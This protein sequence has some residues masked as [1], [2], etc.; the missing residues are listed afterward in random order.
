MIAPLPPPGPDLEELDH[1]MPA[2]AIRR[3]LV[4]PHRGPLLVAPVRIARDQV[5]LPLNRLFR[6]PEGHLPC[7]GQ[8]CPVGRPAVAVGVAGLFDHG[9]YPRGQVDHVQH[10]APSFLPG[11]LWT[12]HGQN[13]PVLGRQ[14]GALS[15]LL[16]R[17]QEF[18]L[19]S[20][21]DADPRDADAPIFL[22]KP[23]A[24][25]FYSLTTCVQDS[26]S[27]TL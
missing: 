20:P 3:D 23:R 9:L 17:S 22:S 18:G 25:A 21:V 26:A 14:P 2:R 24:T 15:H 16:I 12:D 5:C 8:L 1:A 7:I 11:R 10:R 4:S 13:P 27:L 6:L 19:A